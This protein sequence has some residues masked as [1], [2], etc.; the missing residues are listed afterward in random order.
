MIEDHPLFGVGPE[1]IHDEFPK[2]YSG[3]AIDYYGHLH[4]NFL[5]IAA[6]RGLL[7]LA[8]FVWFLVELYRSLL[9]RLGDRDDDTRWVTLGSLAALTGFLVAGMTE[10]NFGDSE[11]FVLL[12]FLIS[13]PIGLVPH[14]QED[15]DRQP[16]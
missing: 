4:N 2:Y 8:A 3:P 6:E 13:V 1:R 10:F 9:R 5:Q 15:P 12:L 16:G 11:V 7:S 14:V